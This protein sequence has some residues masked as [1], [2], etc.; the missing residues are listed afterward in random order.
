M[1]DEDGWYLNVGEKEGTT[2]SA[3]DV[4]SFIGEEC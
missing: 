2:E 3:F 1:K 4:A